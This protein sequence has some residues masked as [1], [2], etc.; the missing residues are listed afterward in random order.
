MVSRLMIE[1]TGIL[2][3]SSTSAIA[4]RLLGPFSWRS[5]A[6]K[7]PQGVAPAWVMISTDS[8]TDVPAVMTSSKIR[9]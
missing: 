7:T 8:R 4:E 9:I 6:I 3:S 1:I 5:K 2:N